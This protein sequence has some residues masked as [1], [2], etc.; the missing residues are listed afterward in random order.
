MK[1]TRTSAILVFLRLCEYDGSLKKVSES[2]GAN[3]EQMKQ[4]GILLALKMFNP[5]LHRLLA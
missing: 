5:F 2:K 1:R 3:S 4:R